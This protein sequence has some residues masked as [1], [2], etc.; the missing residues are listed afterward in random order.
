M[1]GRVDNDGTE[2]R[3]LAFWRATEQTKA[4]RPFPPSTYLLVAPHQRANLALPML[5]ITRI[6]MTSLEEVF[7]HW[8]RGSRLGP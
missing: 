1:H 8:S 5:V 6:S 4:D 2:L 3:H 7:W